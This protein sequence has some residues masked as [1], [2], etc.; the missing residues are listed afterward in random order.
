MDTWGTKPYGTC[1]ADDSQA[2]AIADFFLGAPETRRANVKIEKS[3]L[4]IRQDVDIW[5]MGCVYSEVA[6]WVD[7]GWNK[8]AEYRRRRSEE[9]K[10]KTNRSEDSFHDGLAVLEAVVQI[11]HDIVQNHRR[12][13]FI[14]PNVVNGLVKEMLLVRTTRPD[15]RYLFDKSKRIL[16]DAQMKLET[17]LSYP[18]SPVTARRLPVEPVSLAGHVRQ[19]SKDS[20]GDGPIRP[21]IRP[22][23]PEPVFPDITSGRGLSSAPSGNGTPYVSIQDHQ[24]PFHQHSRSDTVFTY[25]NSEQMG[26]QNDSHHLDRNVG[27]PYYGKNRTESHQ[28]GSSETNELPL[29]LLTKSGTG[30]RNEESITDNRE[31][32]DWTDK[33]QQPPHASSHSLSTIRAEGSSRGKTGQTTN[34]SRPTAF[35]EG[36]NHESTREHYETPAAASDIPHMTVEEGLNVKKEREHGKKVRFPPEDEDLFES[37]HQRDHVS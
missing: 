33:Q 36:P 4:K 6:T 17:T 3:R 21:D 18:I 27:Y 23:N 25:S 24:E 26:D 1:D 35:A 37:L 2:R 13:D 20:S 5:S 29:H 22:L 34:N 14:T 31:P 7:Q 15:A 19:I 28:H 11:H 12:N 32:S 30:M 8:V 16:D 9:M 10:E